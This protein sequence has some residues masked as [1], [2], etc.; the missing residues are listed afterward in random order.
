MTARL[1]LLFSILLFSI[2]SSGQ[3][4][5][6]TGRV[7]DFKDTSALVGVSIILKDGTDTIVKTGLGAV[8]DA[9][10]NFNMSGVVPG[11]YLVHLE[12]IGY[13][14]VNKQLTI[15]DKDLSVGTIAMK[16]TANEL[17][18]VTVTGKQIRAEQKGDTT[19]FHADAYKTHPD[20]T[21][22]D[23]IT[24]M[25]GMTSDN[26]G[27]KVNGEAVQQVYVD[28]KPFFGTDPTLAM[29]NLPAEVI[30]KIQVFDKLSDQATFTGF[31][32]GNSQKTLNIITK[33]SKSEGIFGKV[34]AGYGTDGTYIAGGNLNIFNGDQRISILGLS[35]NINQQ[36]FSSQDILGVTGG[37][38]QGRGGGGGRGA[39]GG[40]GGNGGGGGS[41]NF[42]VNQQNGITTTNSFGLNY[43]DNWGKKIKVTASYF[44]NGAENVNTTGLTR[45]YF[46]GVENGD[47]YSEHDNVDTRNYNHRF[48]LRFEYNI[49]SFNSIIFTPSVSFQQNNASTIQTASTDSGEHVLLNTMNNSSS[50]NNG[51]SSSNNLLIQH[52]FKKPRRTVSLNI[53]TSLNEKTGN[54]IYYA[55]DNEYYYNDS[56]ATPRVSPSTLNQYYTLYNNSYTV[57]A[58]LTYTEPLGKRSQLMVNYY[59]SFTKSIADR[60]TYNFDSATNSYSNLD[61][62]ISNKYHST[63]TAQKGGLSY[64]ISDK[65]LTFSVGANVQYAL[66]QGEEVYP[67]AF[68]LERPFT[69]IL[70]IAFFNYRF[71]DGKN[72]RIMYRTNTV[73]PTITQL[74]DVVD[75]SNPLLLNTGNRDLKQDYEHT[76]I[77]RYGLTKSKT[78]RNFFVYLYG[79]IINNYITNK[80]YQ[81][82]RDTT[83]YGPYPDAPIKV[84]ANSQLTKPWNMDGYYNTR[85]F[86]TYGM[87]A[88]F[89]K[90]NL[91]FNG[92][93]SYTRS[94]G[95]VNDL[96]NYSSNYVPSLGIVLSSNISEKIDFS[97]S[98]SGS[99]NFV[100]NTLQN[101]ANNNYYNHT[102]GFKINWIFAKNFVLNTNIT[103]NYYTA[104]SNTGNQ[105]F[106]LWNAYLG[107]KL[108][109]K[110]ALEI[111]VSAFDILDKNKSITRSV[112]GTYVENDI[113]TVLKQY[114]MLQ[115]TYT[116][117][118]FK[119]VMPT[120][121]Q[122]DDNNARPPWR[123]HMH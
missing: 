59:P 123:D 11:S 116:I 110:Q 108:L 73:A 17:K 82:A 31:D 1:T 10:G 22:E 62:T 114:F 25:P 60:E 75:V 109:K 35:N 95:I 96:A 112:T 84:K 118:N 45:N 103:H 41:N 16:S 23:L 121:Q 33:K 87:P 74:Q 9:D 38:G 46:T 24:K 66:L 113:T 69:S 42:L 83:F 85:A 37:S 52:K 5:T 2:L 48:N 104:F 30:D 122:N 94:P 89:L 36:N 119:G 63:Y 115:L 92:G 93:F 19:S 100:Q 120:L 39:F 98:Y 21:A 99:Y 67:N 54:G 91:N 44:Y 26:S 76:L 102:A 3:T 78:A 88:D 71:E 81:F 105:D 40:G 29:R 107:Y 20:A 58:N 53:N 34:Y 32:D 70:P 47:V 7:A 117:R 28:G 97:L 72:L 51:Y 101:Q 111:R 13:R 15:A 61:D 12:Y 106:W 55:N 80:T 57:G 49:D 68:T 6:I 79:N 65:K 8:T 14:S 56:S 64:R 50:N 43:S 4:F 90:C 18:G 86:F 27:V 77:V